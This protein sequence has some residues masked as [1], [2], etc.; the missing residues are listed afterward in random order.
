MSPGQQVSCQW[1][2]CQQCSGSS[3]KRDSAHRWSWTWAQSLPGLIPLLSILDLP[4]ASS[5]PWLF[6]STC[7]SR[8]TS[9][10]IPL[11]A[12][13]H[14]SSPALVTY[15]PVELL[16]YEAALLPLRVFPWLAQGAHAVQQSLRYI[17]AVVSIPPR[18]LPFSCHTMSCHVM[19]CHGASPA[20]VSAMRYGERYWL[21][22]VLN[23][24]VLSSLRHRYVL[25][26]YS[27]TFLR[28]YISTA[29]HF[30]GPTL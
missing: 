17:C 12:A 23:A 8:M 26:L 6:L 27:C 10:S 13:N 1:L 19:P 28:F 7:A 30:C 3:W 29:V 14:V 20:T 2:F 22:M 18:P 25:Q 5:D 16:R 9:P 11:V 21:G 4:V 24:M 15:S